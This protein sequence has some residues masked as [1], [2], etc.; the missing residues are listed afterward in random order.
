MTGAWR[1]A[2][3]L[4]VLRAEIDAIA[5][6]R[7]RASDGTIGDAAHRNR[8][9]DHNPNPAGVVCAIDI[10]HDPAHGA[11]MARIAEQIR[12]RR[13]PA[14]KYVIFDRRIAS[15]SSGWAWR[16]YT[17]R[18]PHDRH[19]HVSVGVGPDGRSTG[20]YDDTSP[21]GLTSARGK[22]MFC[23]LGDTGEHVQALQAAINAI[24]DLVPRLKEDGV[25][26]PATSAA[27]LAM[28]RSVGSKVTSGD[29]YDAHAYVQLLMCMARRFGDGQP[30]PRGPKGD[31][32]E[33]GPK[34]D[35]GE[36][37]PAG[38]PGEIDY[39]RLVD[40]LLRRLAS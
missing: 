8:A 22:L 30:G 24:G 23:K 25:Y 29:Q 31:P 2:R 36:R 33:R 10:T 1:L 28:R 32:G 39:A 3:A 15:A 6:G 40:E 19:M 27:V 20:P 7:S 16:T 11:D 26:G 37:G 17:G 13:H 34:G 21:W 12:T 4:E 18:D 38:P 9:S 5:P 14:L 35:P